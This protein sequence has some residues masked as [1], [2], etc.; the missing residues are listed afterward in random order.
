MLLAAGVDPAEENEEGDTAAD[1]GAAHEDVTE[2]LE[3]HVE[4]A[5]EAAQEEKYNLQPIQRSPAAGG[6]G[7]GAMPRSRVFAEGG[8]SAEQAAADKRLAASLTTRLMADS[9][10]DKVILAANKRLAG[11]EGGGGGKGRGKYAHTV[12]ASEAPPRPATK[13]VADA[14]V[15]LT[16]RTRVYA[17]PAPPGRKPSESLQVPILAEPA[18]APP[19]A[20]AG[21]EGTP[22]KK[23]WHATK[24]GDGRTYYY[25]DGGETSWERPG[26]EGLAV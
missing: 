11:E 25:S 12:V 23:G 10:A 9:A 5:A 22:L 6:G 16:P 13:F 8:G 24:T 15:A 20:A 17:K 4:R 21:G 3:R 19:R 14:D 26:A 1:F 2:V 18:R 7:A